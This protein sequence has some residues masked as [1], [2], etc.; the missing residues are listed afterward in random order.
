MQL[1]NHGDGHV[2]ICDERHHPE[3]T[4]NLVSES[5]PEVSPEERAAKRKRIE[6]HA[7]H[8]L[9][10][11]TIFIQSASLRGPFESGWLNPWSHANRPGVEQGQDSESC[12]GHEAAPLDKAITKASK[13]AQGCSAKD[14]IPRSKDSKTTKLTNGE[15]TKP[16]VKEAVDVEET[17][18]ALC[19]QVRSGITSAF[20]SDTARSISH[21]QNDTNSQRHSQDL[22]STAKRVQQLDAFSSKLRTLFEKEKESAG[23]ETQTAA[24][25]EISSPGPAHTK[26]LISSQAIHEAALRLAKQELTTPKKS[27]RAFQKKQNGSTQSVN[28]EVV[29]DRFT[30]H[31]PPSPFLVQN[32]TKVDAPLTNDQ[33]FS[34]VERR[35][36]SQVTHT[37]QSYLGINLDLAEQYTNSTLPTPPPEKTSSK[38]ISHQSWKAS[39]ESGAPT[40]L[41]DDPI[42][43]RASKDCSKPPN[44]KI[45]H[46]TSHDK[47]TTTKFHATSR[48]Y[49]LGAASDPT[50]VS[51]Q[52]AMLDARQAL[53]GVPISPTTPHE[54]SRTSVIEN[55]DTSDNDPLQGDSQLRVGPASPTFNTQDLPDSV[56]SFTSPI[57]QKP[58]N[59]EMLCDNVAQEQ[60]L[61]NPRVEPDKERI[62]GQ[63]TSQDSSVGIKDLDESFDVNEAIEDM[64]AFLSDSGN[65]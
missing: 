36:I 37:Q 41:I 1:I 28:S 52:E 16:H 50:V 27:R 9:K 29:K 51:T 13:R 22:D 57:T 6:Q 32:V 39:W 47:N 33:S 18:K 64:S 40:C 45:L 34:S 38:S 8:Y 23:R 54:I 3:E 61:E 59:H 4:E 17:P 12:N 60:L 42:K 46:Q 31:S 65:R 43:L 5:E 56:F 58:V 20:T 24:E 35:H 62:C 10:H 14:P 21:A 53:Q 7:R 48:N 19:E 49:F 15:L 44:P 30:F 11:Q 2:E 63:T 55:P 25:K 26:S